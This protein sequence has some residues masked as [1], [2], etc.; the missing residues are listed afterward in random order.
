MARVHLVLLRCMFACKAT[1]GPALG[2]IAGQRPHPS[3]T[4]RP[5]ET[6]E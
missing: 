1:A 6:A 5:A 2:I 4:A 3:S